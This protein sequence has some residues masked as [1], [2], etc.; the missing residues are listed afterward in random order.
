MRTS[1]YI[2][3]HHR[4]GTALQT[5]PQ[6][7]P[8]SFSD[9]QTHLRITGTSEQ[10]YIEGLVTAARQHAERYTRRAFITQTWLLSLDH[11]PGG[12]EP[13]WDGVRQGSIRELYS[14][15]RW[16]EL[17]YPPLQTVNSVKQFDTD[18]NADTVSTDIYYVDTNSEPGRVVLRYGKTWPSVTNRIADSFQVDYDA[19]YGDN[20][21]DVP[22]PIRE[23]VKRLAGYLYEHRGD[24]SAEEALKGSGAAVLLDPYRLRGL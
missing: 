17:P 1:S 20:A 8:V 16:V 14:Y 12:H 11:P 9:M 13:W 24:C 21:D 23:A 4:R 15:A 3:S 19:G 7:E 2:A 18:D 22:Q 6:T 10:T 5:E